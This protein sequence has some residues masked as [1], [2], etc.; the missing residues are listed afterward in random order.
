MII[1]SNK[2]RKGGNVSVRKVLRQ[3]GPV[4]GQQTRSR[5]RGA[6]GDPPCFPTGN[7]PGIKTLIKTQPAQ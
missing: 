1:E 2:S 5:E 7:P 4:P 6:N 3:E